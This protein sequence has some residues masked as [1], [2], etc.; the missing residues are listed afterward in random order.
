MLRYYIPELHEKRGTGL[1]N[2]SKLKPVFKDAQDLAEYRNGLTHS[3]KMPAAVMEALPKLIN[4]VSD[5]LY[6]IDILEGHE[7]AKECVGLHTVGG[8]MPNC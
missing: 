2:W 6:I 1:A 4:S 3:G 5:L 7:W 8:Q